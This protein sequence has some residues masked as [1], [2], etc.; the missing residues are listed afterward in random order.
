MAKLHCLYGGTRFWGQYGT[1]EKLGI[2]DVPKCWKDLADPRFKNEIQMA[3]PQSSGTAYTAIATFVQLWG[4]E[5][6]FDYLKQLD[7]H[8]SQYP[9]AGTA[10]SRNTAR[11][12]LLASAS[13][14]TILLKRKWCANRIGCTL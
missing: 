8:I 1:F 6:A 7:Q 10:P 9:K 2:K 14:K 3:D 13:Y 5:Q 4:E 12:P 11:K